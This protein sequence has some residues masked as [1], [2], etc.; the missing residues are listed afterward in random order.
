MDTLK[1]TKQE[2]MLDAKREKVRVIPIQYFDDFPGHPFNVKMDEEM[3]A[4]IE[5]IKEFGILTPLIARKTQ[6]E[7][8]EIIAGHR[9]KFAAK[10]LGILEL[11]VIL[12]G[13]NYPAC[14]SYVRV[15]KGTNI[16]LGTLANKKLRELRKEAHRY[17]DMLYKTGLI[18]KTSAYEWLSGTLSRP[19]E[20]AHIGMLGEY[21]C[22]IVIEESKKYLK[23]ER[24]K[25]KARKEDV[26]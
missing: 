9:R 10:K 26:A 4:L 11:P 2:T 7:R 22:Q 18:T 17:F 14:D 13:K 12:R 20:Y 1:T 21:D 3:K 23:M 5:S 6:Q 25:R 19:L 8:Y 15:Q 16:P 24:E